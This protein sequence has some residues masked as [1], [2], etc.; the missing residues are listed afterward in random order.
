[1][2]PPTYPRIPYLVAPP[3]L[4]GS[5][6]VVPVA[7]VPRWFL[8]PVHVEEKLDGANVS[9]WLEE[10]QIQ[11][12][13]R[14]G[15]GAMDRAGQL[16]RLRA[17]VAESS[18]RL[19]SLLAGGWSTYGEWLW[20]RHG[21]AYDRLPD[22]LVVLDL[23][24]PDAGM[25]SVSER[26]ARLSAAGLLMP[27]VRHSGVLRDLPALLSL[28][29]PSAYADTRAEGLVVR[30]LADGARCKVVDPVYQRPDDRHFAAGVRNELAMC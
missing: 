28:L 6:R 3:H 19:T 7:E 23:W 24:H 22:F 8:T 21:I 2:T 18:D 25:A 1:M 20:L 10:G 12:A 30:R 17:W 13:T 9:L 4:S 14:G 16:G 27:P 5:D 26:D 11:V 15:V 29:G